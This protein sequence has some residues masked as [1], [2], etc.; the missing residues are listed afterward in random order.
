MRRFAVVT[1]LTAVAACFAL[2]ARADAHPPWG[3]AADGQG[4][5]YFS[6]LET[7]WKIDERGRLSVFRPGVSGRHT[8]ELTLGEDGNIYGE[9]LT[10]EPSGE[11]W[12]TAV[13]KAT[14]SGDVSYLLAPT[15]SPPR[16]TSIWRDREGN[17]YSVQSED[18]AKG[19]TLLKRSPA[20]QVSLLL[21]DRAAFERGRQVILYNLAGTAFG[22]DGALYFTNRTDI[23]KAERDGTI[24]TLARGVAGAA[25]P[26]QP[27]AG[28]DDHGGLL[29]LAVDA[30]GFVYAA[31]I[32]NRR[33]LKVTPDGKVSTV[34][35]SEGTWMPTGVACAGGN[36]YVLE[37]GT[38]PSGTNTPPRVLK[39]TPGGRPSVLASVAEAGD[40]S[41]REPQAA[42]SEANSG[43]SGGGRV[44]YVDY[45]RVFRAPVARTRRMVYALAGTAAVTLM[46]IVY[47]VARVRRGRR[48]S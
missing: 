17:T 13:W 18:P 27:K 1:V 4:R 35:T 26:N 7:V 25:T 46:L 15:D 48:L 29:G 47:A 12:I 32:A 34:H 37:F 41:A 44:D 40:A 23:F 31:D 43:G 39:L 5:V 42:A 30:Q 3:I 28:H 33:V 36:I 38:T 21:G 8:H 19:F 22:P 14:P 45:H 10:Y 20:G 9:D 11:R 24:K 2:A 6:A 16:G